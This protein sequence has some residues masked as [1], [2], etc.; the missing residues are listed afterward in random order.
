MTEDKITRSIIYRGRRWNGSKVT[1]SW[2]AVEG[3]QELSFAKVAGTVIG[4]IYE[5]ATL[6]GDEITTVYP[7]TLGYSGSKHHDDAEVAIW[8]ASDSRVRR[9]QAS[10]K[11]ERAAARSGPLDDA[12]EPMLTLG[13]P[14]SHVWDD[15]WTVATNDGSRCAQWEHT[16]VVTDTGAEILTTPPAD[17]A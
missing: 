16:I 7:S 8:Q 12:I 1:H 17:F 3:G 6:P 15:D 5:I 4:G 11:A 2:Q 13:D 9:E 14:S 10:Q